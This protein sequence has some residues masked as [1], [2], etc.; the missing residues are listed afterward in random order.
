MFAAHGVR[1]PWEPLPATGEVNHIY[2]TRD[3]V[4]RVGADHPD[5]VADARTEAVAAPAAHAAG[6]LTP[7]LIAF[8]DSRSL[9]DRPYS[10]WQR[11]HGETLGLLELEP[12][13]AANVWRSVGRELAR[14][15]HRVTVCPD[16]NGWLD[17]HERP[18]DLT[19]FVESLASLGRIDSG[20]S[21]ET[22]RLLEQLAPHV[23]T[24]VDRRF[25]H[26]DIHP[27]NVM[28][29]ADG[30]LLA[31]I[32]W[33]DAG[34]ADPALDF[35]AIPVE[36]MPDAVAGYESAGLGRLGDSPGA[37]FA[38]DKL[39]YAMEDLLEHPERASS[40]SLPKLVPAIREQQ[41]QRLWKRIERI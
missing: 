41:G 39:H 15:H 8:D 11:V 34:W 5:T 17:T 21:S 10:L 31:L 25:I 14:L 20:A 37:R 36:S 13:R 9:T 12:S 16:P 26:G 19:P 28:C 23:A 40:I 27:M 32:D 6:I 4:L 30:E 38:W 18:A 24:N 22:L 1:G 7:R 35:A 2:A 33:G 3:V 29:T